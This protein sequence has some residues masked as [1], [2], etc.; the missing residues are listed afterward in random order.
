MNL[1]RYTE[2]ARQHLRQ[3]IKLCLSELQLGLSKLW[4]YSAKGLLS[5]PLRKSCI[6]LP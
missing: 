4:R 2:S 6:L 3:V 1:G 5:Y